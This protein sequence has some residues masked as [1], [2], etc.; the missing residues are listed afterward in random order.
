MIVGI[1]ARLIKLAKW[2]SL[3][4]ETTFDTVGVLK[5]WPMLQDDL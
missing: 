2:G 3:L 5:W 1:R 4:K